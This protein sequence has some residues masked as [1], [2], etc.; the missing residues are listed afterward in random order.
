[1]KKRKPPYYWKSW[2]NT[3]GELKK[4]IKQ[5][6][7][8]FPSTGRLKELGYNQLLVCSI[9]KYFGGIYQIRKRM[10]Y[11]TSKKYRGF[12]KNWTNF[13]KEMKKAIRKNND[14]FPTPRILN[15]MGY[16]QL[17]AASL[18]YYG[19]LPAVRERIGYH[20]QKRQELA[21]KLEKIIMEI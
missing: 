14:E 16:S 11:Q 12:W 18:N 21:R 6:N 1:M 3:R 8:E 9:K 4:A 5:N 2:K 19:G 10:G 17:L 15:E 13:E 7:G 20:E